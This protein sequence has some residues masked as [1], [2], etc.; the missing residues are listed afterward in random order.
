MED[1]DAFYDEHF[2]HVLTE[3]VDGQVWYVILFLTTTRIDYL[4]N[5]VQDLSHLTQVL[6]YLATQIVTSINNNIKEHYVRRL[7][8]FIDVTGQDYETGLSN[9]EVKRERKVTY[10]CM[11]ILRIM[12]LVLTR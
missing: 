4:G 8:R 3:D 11:Q 1:L 7:F 12:Y 6:L 2:K 9:E 10:A 5:T